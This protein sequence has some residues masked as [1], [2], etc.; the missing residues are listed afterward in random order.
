M[1]LGCGVVVGAFSAWTQLDIAGTDV[2]DWT[3]TG[4]KQCASTYAI[5]EVFFWMHE[6]F[7]KAFPD[8]AMPI[9]LSCM[10]CNGEN[11][12]MHYLTGTPDPLMASLPNMI[13][14]VPTVVAWHK[15]ELLIS[16]V[17]RARD[18][19][20]MGLESLL[21][22]CHLACNAIDGVL[23]YYQIHPLQM[24]PIHDIALT[25]QLDSTADRDH[26]TDH[27]SLRRWK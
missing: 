14:N 1:P 21:V 19:I 3:Q 25:I 27:A 10:A 16:T 11:Y 15:R 8:S 23:Q 2:S 6:K 24:T 13:M 9:V 12:G 5:S 18:R 22:D 7:C 17:Q 4:L 26:P 20:R